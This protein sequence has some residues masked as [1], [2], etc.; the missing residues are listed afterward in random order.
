MVSHWP[1][2]HGVHYSLRYLR[3]IFFVNPNI[4]L[5]CQYNHIFCGYVLI[6]V[7]NI[8][9]T[10]SYTL[11]KYKI[12]QSNIK[13]IL[14]YAFVD[15]V[16]LWYFWYHAMLITYNDIKIWFTH[17]ILFLM[18]C[19]TYM[20]LDIIF[21]STCIWFTWIFIMT[22]LACSCRYNDQFMQVSIE[23]CKSYKSTRRWST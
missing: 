13:I 16:H 19:C 15:I 14:I 17:M 20:I 6:W 8:M 22:S 18:I 10:P 1:L 23:H 21:M 9:M 4:C 3:G 5:A 11:K 12:K 7:W 2:H